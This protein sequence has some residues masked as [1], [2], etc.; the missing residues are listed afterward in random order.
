M[1]ICWRI[2]GQFFVLHWMV[3]GIQITLLSLLPMNWEIPYTI[4]WESYSLLYTREHKFNSNANDSF[5][6]LLLQ[7]FLTSFIKEWKYLVSDFTIMALTLLTRLRKILKTK[8]LNHDHLQS[9]QSI[10]QFSLYSRLST[11]NFILQKQNSSF[12]I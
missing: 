8:A 11:S 2:M 6:V 5:W 7:S 9:C 3:S 10:S 4:S 12:F 1:S